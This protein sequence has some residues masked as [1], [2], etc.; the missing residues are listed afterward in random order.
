V[1]VTTYTSVVSFHTHTLQSS[2]I[3][4]SFLVSYAQ[5]HIYGTTFF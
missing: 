3:L 5:V 1:N 2:L 4:V